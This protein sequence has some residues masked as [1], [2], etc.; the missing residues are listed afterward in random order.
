MEPLGLPEILAPVLW[1][2]WMWSLHRYQFFTLRMFFSNFANYTIFSVFCFDFDST[3]LVE[4]AGFC[5]EFKSFCGKKSSG[6]TTL[7]LKMVSTFTRN[8]RV[9]RIFSLFSWP[10]KLLWGKILAWSRKTLHHRHREFV[11]WDISKEL[12][13]TAII[14]SQIGIISKPNSHAARI[15]RDFNELYLLTYRRNVKTTGILT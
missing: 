5:H 2:P 11:I 12:V 9:H 4:L 7:T 10:R 15:A 14:L 13:A 8:F 1:D 6:G 3:R